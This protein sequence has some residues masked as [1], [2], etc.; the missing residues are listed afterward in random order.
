MNDSIKKFVEQLKNDHKDELLLQAGRKRRRF[1]KRLKSRLLS[2]S[3][4][5]GVSVKVLA[6]AIGINPDTVRDWKDQVRDTGPRKN[7][8]NSGLFKKLEIDLEPTPTVN[9]TSTHYV[10][11]K[12]GVRVIGLSLSQMADLLRCL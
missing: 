11:G 4:S 2:E 6:E 3:N 5:S 12:F 8:K 9:Q 1:S 7:I 10:E